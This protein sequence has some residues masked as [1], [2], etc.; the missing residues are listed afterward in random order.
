MI[1]VKA[2]M[3]DLGHDP[4]EEKRAVGKKN[5]TMLKIKKNW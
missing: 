2:E 5:F 3:I 1:I 4:Q